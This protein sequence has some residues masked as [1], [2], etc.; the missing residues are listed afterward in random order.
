[1]YPLSSAEQAR[2]TLDWIMAAVEVGKFVVA[3]GPPV[4]AL[5]VES[6]PKRPLFPFAFLFELDS[7]RDVDAMH[8]RHARRRRH[9]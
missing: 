7:K 2:A 8:N 9:Q 6:I 1:M 4:Y 5:H 3:T